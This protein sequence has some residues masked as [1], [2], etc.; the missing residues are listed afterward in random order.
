MGALNS[1]DKFKKAVMLGGNMLRVNQI[2][3]HPEAGEENI[4]KKAAAVLGIKQVDIEKLVIMKQ[5][6]D[7]RKKPEIFY[8]YT[9][10]L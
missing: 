6:I 8:S 4:R 3:V 5:S 2:K 9:V 7:A 1:Y 10:D